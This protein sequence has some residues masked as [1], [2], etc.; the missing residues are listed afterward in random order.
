MKK[1][2]QDVLKDIESN[3]LG[4]EL[5]GISG[6]AAAFSISE[7]DYA[8]ENVV[9]NVQGKRKTWTFERMKKVWQEMY[10][11]PA[12]NVEIVFG[13]SGS[14][15][16]QVETIYASLSYVEWLYVKSKKCVAYIGEETHP[17]GELQHMDEEKEL[18]YQKLMESANPRNPLLE[19]D[20]QLEDSDEELNEYQ[21]AARM[22]KEYVLEEGY[23]F[24][25]NLEDIKESLEYF[26][27]TYS[28]ETLEKLDDNHIL[29]GMFYTIT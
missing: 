20:E 16:N 29:A 12:A 14:S 10:Y 22:L 24:P 7:I 13:G 18:R 2:F 1:T 3:L 15:R 19:P 26:Q 27:R 25:D 8:N 5:H 23:E 4:K 9:L 6:N 17:Y 21:L 28:P 11:H